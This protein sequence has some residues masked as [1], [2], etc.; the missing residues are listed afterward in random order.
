MHIA[1]VV[2]FLPNWEVARSF[3][4]DPVKGDIFS[5]FHLGAGLRKYVSKKGRVWLLLFL[6]DKW[7]E[8]AV[9]VVLMRSQSRT[10]QGGSLSSMLLAAIKISYITFGYDRQLLRQR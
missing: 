9:D 10:L 7:S 6:Y 3:P 2:Y 4:T 1:Q 8:E 5:E